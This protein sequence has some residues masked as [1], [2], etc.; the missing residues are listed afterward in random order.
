M[1]AYLWGPHSI[2][3]DAGTLMYF[4][5]LLLFSDEAL[6]L[7]SYCAVSTDV[8]IQRR[9]FKQSLCFWPFSWKQTVNL[10]NTVS[11]TIFMY[12]PS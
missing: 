12:I 8:N 10:N 9:I 3:Y 1:D 11:G 7:D 4:V 2:L 6:P 5:A